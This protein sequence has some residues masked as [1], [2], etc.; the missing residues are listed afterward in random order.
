MKPNLENIKEWLERYTD[1]KYNDV[2]FKQ[3]DIDAIEECFNLY[4]GD[5][6]LKSISSGKKLKEKFLN[7]PK[8]IK[9]SSTFVSEEHKAADEMVYEYIYSITGTR[10][11]K[12]RADCC[13][14]N[15]KFENY[16]FRIWHC[17]WNNQIMIDRGNHNEFIR[18][19]WGSLFNAIYDFFDTKEVYKQQSLF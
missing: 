16:E 18:I 6:D 15:K 14:I 13:S 1:T 10:V 8:A 4:I 9:F 11:L 19:M 2:E 12:Y 5:F 3:I 7:F 17:H